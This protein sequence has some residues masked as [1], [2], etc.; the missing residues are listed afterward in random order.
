MATQTLPLVIIV[1]AC[2]VLVLVK[3]NPGAWSPYHQPALGP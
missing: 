2:V 1:L 3:R